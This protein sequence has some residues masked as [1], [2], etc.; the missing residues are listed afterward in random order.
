MKIFTAT[1][2]CETNTFSPIKTDMDSF[3]NA[4]LY[5]PGEHPDEAFETTA[6]LWACR[7]RVQKS[8]WNV[9]EGTCAT[10]NPG[11]I[12]LQE[13]YE[14]LRDEILSQLAAALPVDAIAV[15][16]HGAM[17][18]EGYH[19]CEGDFLTRA[20][21]IVGPGIPIGIEIDPHAHLSQ[22]MVDKADVIIAFKEYPH[23]DFRERACELLDILSAMTEDRVKPAMS[24][25]DC[26]MVGVY[27]TSQ[28]PMKSFLSE[29]RACEKRDG[30]LSISLIHGFPW[31]D[32]EDMGT[33]ILVVTND[34]KAAGNALAR[35]LGEKVFALRENTAAPDLSLVGAVDQI[36]QTTKKPIIVA[37]SSDNPGGGAPG[38]STF[39]MAELLRRNLNGWCIGPVCDPAAVGRAFAAG[40]GA[41]IVLQIGG[42]YGA[43]S[44]AP[45]IV[46]VTVA[47]LRR[48]AVQTFANTKASLG[49]SAAVLVGGNAIVLASI[50]AQALGLDLFTGVGIEPSEYRLVIVKSSQH[51][52]EEFSALSDEVVYVDAGGALSRKLNA[53]DYCHVRRPKWPFDENPWT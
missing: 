46:E 41:R 5:R 53:N 33:K 31:G 51:F 26:R 22:T 11:G 40:I 49:D 6:P 28:E 4:G 45:L 14:E 20:R 1:L 48:N 13:T 10:A 19:D 2:W 9:V 42:H 39:L 23:I 43:A 15:S 24:V 3:R 16:M 34:D 27:H 38:D 25:F 29:L 8:G 50:R 17:V 32:V 36:E 21:A 12:T 52:L 37:D 35:Q 47:G 7:Q 44:G 18:A 30:I